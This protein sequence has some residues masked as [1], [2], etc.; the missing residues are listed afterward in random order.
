[1]VKVYKIALTG[2]PCSGKTS[3]MKTLIDKFSGEFKVFCLPEMATTIVNAG[4]TII[5][6]EFTETSHTVFT[7]GICQLQMDVEKFFDNE[8]KTQK[9]D[10]II[11]TDRGVMDNFAY[12]SPAVRSR[13][14]KETGWNDNFVCMERYDLVIHLVTA[15]QG[16]SEFYSL[17]NNEARTETPELAKFFDFQLSF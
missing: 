16:A 13:V 7:K 2:G 5:P 15:A 8:A 3:S 17:E 1:M 11:I 6:S 10:V 12:C 14:F 9:K 4:V